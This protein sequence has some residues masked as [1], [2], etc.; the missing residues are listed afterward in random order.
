MHLSNDLEIID[1]F[2]NETNELYKGNVMGPHYKKLMGL[3]HDRGKTFKQFL[4][5]LTLRNPCDKC[6][7]K[8]ICSKIDI[9]VC[10]QKDNYYG[11]WSYI[12]YHKAKILKVIS[13]IKN[14]DYLYV[15]FLI[16]VG[17]FY[18]TIAYVL[19]GTVRICLS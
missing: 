4:S 5:K 6:L 2:I 7:I 11:T 9:D 16:T 10:E 18:A 13:F 12:E 3:C 14:I 15:L 1:S 19:I 8:M 17:V